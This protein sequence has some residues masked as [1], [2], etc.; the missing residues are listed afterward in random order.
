MGSAAFRAMVFGARRW[1]KDD[2]VA[3]RRVLEVVDEAIGEHALS[4]VECRFHRPRGDLVSGDDPVL[5]GERNRDGTHGDD[6]QLDDPAGGG[7][8]L[9]RFELQVEPPPTGLL[10]SIGAR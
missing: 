8:R 5:A 4:D 9:G 3:D 6:H 1:M 7:L 10:P 2:D